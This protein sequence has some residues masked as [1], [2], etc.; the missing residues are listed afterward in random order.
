M[1]KFLLISIAVLFACF[2][3]ASFIATNS[4]A[5][6]ASNGSRD[7]ISSVSTGHQNMLFSLNENEEDSIFEMDGDVLPS[8]VTMLKKKSFRVKKSKCN[9]SSSLLIDKKSVLKATLFKSDI[10]FCLIHFKDGALNKMAA[11]D[12]SSLSTAA[13]ESI[14]QTS[15]TT[16]QSFLF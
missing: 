3:G 16:L 4:K 8:G 9:K 1:K 11:K 10:E 2:Y 14:H 6:D 13:M 7:G 12:L 15:L 5:I